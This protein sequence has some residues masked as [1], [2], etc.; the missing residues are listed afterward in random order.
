MWKK[1][2][3]DEALALINIEKQ[4]LLNLDKEFKNYYDINEKI[5][6]EQKA[7]VYKLKQQYYNVYLR[8]I[9]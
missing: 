2:T 6:K 4:N 1:Q 5:C 3:Q 7:I 8:K 9:K